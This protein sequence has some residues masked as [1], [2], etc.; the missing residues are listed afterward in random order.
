LGRRERGAGK[1]SRTGERVSKGR[2]H[3]R[4]KAGAQ[5]AAASPATADAAVTNI[6][7]RRGTGF[8]AGG[9]RCRIQIP[10]RRIGVRAPFHDFGADAG[11]GVDTGR[12][13]THLRASTCTVG[14]KDGLVFVEQRNDIESRD[15]QR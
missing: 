5:T 1:A 8:R 13:T 4:Q 3:A 6:C 15:G 9:F 2:A 14:A 11:I 12:G 7:A 10:E